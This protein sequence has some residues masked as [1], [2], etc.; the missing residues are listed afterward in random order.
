MLKRISYECLSQ[1]EVLAVEVRQLVDDVAASLDDDSVKNLVRKVHTLHLCE[2]CQPSY[3][4]DIVWYM[5]SIRAFLNAHFEFDVL[6]NFLTPTYQGVYKYLPYIWIL[7]T[8]MFN[9]L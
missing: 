3:T 9:R 6:F 4:I 2:I 5:V 8:K 1:L 7:V